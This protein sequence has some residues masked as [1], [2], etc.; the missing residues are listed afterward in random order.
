MKLI[1]SAGRQL[2]RTARSI[3][4]RVRGI[5]KSAYVRDRKVWAGVIIIILAA[6]LWAL[7]T[8]AA[9]APGQLGYSIKRGEEF[10][11][12]NLA[13]LPSWRDQLRLDF[14]NNRVLEAA[15]IADQANRN[16]TADQAKTAVTINDLL[17]TYES[18]Y[19]ARTTALN[20]KLADHAKIPKADATE[21]Q[22]DAVD[23]YDELQ[24][25]RL[26]APAKAQLAV[27]T[28]IDDAQ[29]NIAA[30]KDAL[31]AKP[32]STSDLSRL[33]K[34]ITI[35]VITKAQA[36]QLAAITSNRQLHAELV[37]MIDSGQLPSDI[38]Y[39]LD[40]DLI[41]Q[42]DPAHAK[43]FDAVSE[44]EQMQRIS[45]VVAASRPTA[46]QQQ[47]VQTYLRG[48]QPGQVVPADSTQQYVTPVVY[49]IALSGRLLSDLRSLSGVPM[50]GDDQKLFN[51][52]K[53]IVDPP[54]LS[55]IYQQLT[56]AAQDQ[57]Q[58][59]L[60]SMTRMQEE[61]VA[62]QQAQISYLVMPPGWGTAQ[63]GKLNSQMGVEIATEQ[64]QASKQDT[65]QALA[66]VSA[67]QQQLQ[68]KLDA[69]EATHTE[70]VTKLQAQINNFAGTPDQLAQLKSDLAALDQAQA[71]T[72]NNVQA[73]LTSITTAHTQL[74]DS[75]ENLRQEQ[76]TNLTELELRAAT[77]AQQLTDSATAQLTASL[78]QIDSR[79]QTLITN[80]Q[81]K[82]DDLGGSQDQLRG[83]LNAEITTIK[84]DY[85]ALTTNVQSQLN[86][87]VATTSQLQTTLTQ[88]QNGLASEQTKLTDLTS[89]TT[90]LS[91]LVNQV[92]TDAASQAQDLQ[93]QVNVVKLDQQT[94]NAA[95]A[96]L[97][98]V[99]QTSQSLITGLQ[100]RVD[101]LDTSQT[102]LRTELTA[103]IQTVQANYT[104]LAAYT[105]AQLDAG[106]ATTTQLGT[107]LQTVQTSLSQHAT[108][109]ASLTTSNT[110]LTQL[111]N[112]V[113]AD[114]TAQVGNLQGQIDGLATGQQAIQASLTTLQDQQTADITQLSSQLAV[115]NVLQTQAQ[116]TITAL[117]QQQ[118]QAQADI[119]TLSTNFGVLQTAFDTSQQVQTAMQSNIADQQSALDSLQT[120]TQTSI[121]T[122]T[123]Q[124]TQLAGQISSL[125]ANTATLSQVLT[126][127]QASNTATQSQ[128]NTLL[129]NPPWAIPAGT[130]V[131]QSQ[132]DTLSTQINTQ[133][134]AKSAALDAQLQTYQQTL[135]ASVSQLNA[136]VQSLSTT[137]TNTAT[138][139]TQQQTQINSLSSQI[140]TLQTQVQQ[141]LNA[142]TPHGTGL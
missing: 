79:S 112:Q 113:K 68:A 39:Q 54:N 92:K 100:G 64:F 80:L 38:I 20:Q 57:P 83:Q 2:K 6:V 132:F 55:D 120:Q 131:T 53:A 17:G 72:I 31:G 66:S 87:G 22:R 102:Q 125:A 94:T 67:T 103:E 37:S 91:Q 140:Q 96:S 7:P 109:L 133:F 134:A 122:L 138:A 89:S 142:A 23:T 16:G 77:K 24:L 99:S 33:S 86:A 49:G 90:A 74:G 76:V 105:Q 75:I 41:K 1:R 123:Q 60:R 18:V 104:Q 111:V 3:T 4:K 14:A 43:S 101:S 97:Q 62:A 35:G 48:Y 127:V 139:Q 9:K 10:L 25:L 61:L 36:D 42:V 63:L 137:T 88:V 121:D 124:Q 136:Q 28:S 12:S 21:F 56:T 93:N 52:W 50:N 126:T 8:Y 135:N 46:A 116:A 40:E 51:K 110:V 73:Q 44:F 78:N 106:V 32:L 117:D 114:S 85:Q 30:L 95:V 65:N 47:A 82:V 128:L 141:L 130:Y 58:L 11:A 19:E 119:N 108:Q 129:A 81:T 5:S 34:L 107:D 84:A 59:S 27:L 118:T 45:A 98:T 26:Q 71:T 29:T 69:L 15:Y 115:L 13:P 70:T